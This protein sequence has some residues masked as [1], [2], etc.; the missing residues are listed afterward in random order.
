M[1]GVKPGE[2]PAL[3]TMWTMLGDPKFSI[4]VPCWVGIDEVADPLTDP[5]GGEIGEIAITLRDWSRTGIDHH[6]S[7]KGLPGIWTDVWPVEDDIVN[8]TMT[9]IEQMRGGKVSRA[10]LNAL[11]VEKA[12]DAYRA[13]QKELR[14]MK[15]AAL[16]TAP[17]NESAF[18]TVRVAIYDREGS[19]SKG[20]TNLQRFLTNEHGFEAQRVRAEDIR[21][22]ALDNF[23]V[24]IMPGGSGGAQAKD[25]TESGREQVRTFVR[26][27]GGY[28]GICAGSYLASSHYDWSLHII[29]ARVWDRAHWARGQGKVQLIM[30]DAGRTILAPGQETVDVFYSQG[31]LLV[32]DTKQSLPRYQVM[33]TFGSEVADKGAQPD[34]M[35]GTHAIIRSKFGRGRVICFS[36]HPEVKDGPNDLM[37]AGVRWA[38]QVDLTRPRASE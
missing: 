12:T 17:S 34:A 24:L 9:A 2:D 33:A 7:T 16:A 1:H 36:P 28:V 38:G 15:E 35:R 31:P 22:N 20:P 19:T 30:S 23:D 29:N 10:R 6:F 14:D 4:A 11:H 8:E 5:R 27:G 37:T 26:Q 21:K 25:L 3:T 18:E 13:M 32:P